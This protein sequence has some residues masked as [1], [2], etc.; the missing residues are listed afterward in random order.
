MHHP[1]RRN[2]TTSMVGVKYAKISPE[3]VNPRDIAGNAEEEEEWWTPEIQ[4]GM[5]KKKKNS[6]PQI[7]LGT[8]KKKSKPTATDSNRRRPSRGTSWSQQQQPPQ[9]HHH[10]QQPPQNHHHHYQQPPQ[11]HHHH[12][13]PPQNHHHHYQQPPRN[14]HHY[15][16]PPQNHHHYQQPP[17]NHHHHYQQPPQNH[18][19]HYQ[20]PPQNHHHYQRPL[21]VTR[22]VS[23]P[24]S[25]GHTNTNSL[26]TASKVED[27]G[28]ESYLWRDFSGSSHTS[29]LRFG[30]PVAT[31]P[32]AWRYK[33]SAGTGRPGVSVLWLDEVESWI[34]NFYLSVTTRKIVWA[35]PSL[36]YTHMLLGR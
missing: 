31:L 20:R 4:L 2:V 18:H 14:H 21:T 11:I 35:D 3:I 34:C 1:R 32:G 22:T 15:Q 8:Q 10:Y 12:Q 24:A 26:R 36:R 16:Q 13:Q 6:E 17:Q 25:T 7:Q 33:V 19:H 5:Q 27:L 28:F 23:P 29:D 9:N 30:T